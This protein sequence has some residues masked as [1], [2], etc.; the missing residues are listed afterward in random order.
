TC[1]LFVEVGAATGEALDE[2]VGEVPFE[3]TEMVGDVALD[4]RESMFEAGEDITG[5]D[6]RACVVDEHGDSADGMLRDPAGLVA[7]VEES[8]QVGEQRDPHR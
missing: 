2:D 7:D 1:A 4:E 8:E 3:V 6:I 5:L